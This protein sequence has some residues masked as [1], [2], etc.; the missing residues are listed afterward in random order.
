MP[1][2][3]SLMEEED[4]AAFA[5]VDEAATKNWGYAQ[6]MAPGDNRSRQTLVEEWT[7]ASFNDSTLAW[8]K[9]VDTDLNDE[10]IAGALWKFDLEVD[11]RESRL[12]KD[13]F[14]N[15]P[16]KSCHGTGMLDTMRGNWERFQSKFFAEEPFA[17]LQV[18]ATHPLH[19]RRGAG[20]M[21]VDWGCEK[22]DERGALS[23]LVA[24]K[25]GL[26]LYLSCGFEVVMEY[27][28]DLHPFG[29]EEV[30]LRRACVRK[31]KPK[32]S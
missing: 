2:R 18:L 21:L 27:E 30:E 6:A 17:N 32:N 8:L 29:V 28:E 19:H 31:P 20:R 22:A 5:A 14:S 4:I 12:G 15:A 13:E 3:L 10:L 23:V 25:A 24:S 11:D 16:A 7:R 9:V 1:L 26:G